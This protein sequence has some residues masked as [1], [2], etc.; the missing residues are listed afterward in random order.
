MLTARF[1]SFL[2]VCP[3][4]LDADTPWMQTLSPRMQIPLLADPPWMQTP[5][6]GQTNTCE[7]ITLRQTSFAGS[8]YVQLYDIQ[9]RL[10]IDLRW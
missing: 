9:R 4:L 3:T 6:C 1:S 8:K 10:G 2:G 5:T 7:N